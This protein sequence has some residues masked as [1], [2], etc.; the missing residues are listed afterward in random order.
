MPVATEVEHS[1]LGKEQVVDDAPKVIRELQFGVLYD[2]PS[3]A[4]GC[5]PDADDCAGPIK[6]SSTSLKSNSLTGAYL[7]STEVGLMLNMG[8]STSGWASQAREKSVKP[9]ANN[10]RLA[11]ATSGT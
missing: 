8:L 2:F 1:T 10:F 6:T 5:V 7:T 3:A 9:A 11:M 4:G